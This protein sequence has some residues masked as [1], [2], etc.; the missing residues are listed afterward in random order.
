MDILYIIGEGCSKCNNNELRYSLRSIEQYGQNVGH[1]FVAGF[2]PDWL[3]DKV[4]KIP[5]DDIYEDKADHGKRNANVLNKLLVAVDS[6][7][8]LGDEFLVSFDD[9]FYIRE[10]DFDNYPHYVRMLDGTVELPRHSPKE[11]HYR[12]CLAETRLWLEKLGLPFI[13]FAVHRNLHVTKRAIEENREL[14]E[15]IV[16]E[17]I[18]CDRFILL[19]NWEYKNGINKF[20]L[21]PVV[22]IKLQ[23]GYDWWRVNPSKTEC[24][25]TVD[26]NEGVGLDCLLKGMFNKKSKYEL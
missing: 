5:C 20:K 9:N 7:P 15:K 24:F 8:E 10:T 26:F 18:P 13:N 12:H 6:T 21:R 4:T 11:S 23:G 1:I 14:L 16:V 22:D 19:N 3:S 17:R 25:S 2:C